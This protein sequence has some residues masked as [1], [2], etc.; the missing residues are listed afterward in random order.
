MARVRY[1]SKSRFKLA[2]ECPTKLFFTGKPEYG[3]NNLDNAFLEALAEGGFQVGELAK[4]YFPNGHEIDTLDADEAVKRTTELLSQ[5]KVTIYEPAFIFGKL[6]VRVD[7]LVKTGKSI[8]LVEVK[9]KSFDKSE[10]PSE[11]PGFGAMSSS[12]RSLIK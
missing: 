12:V 4:L 5:D 2:S 7:V 3:N 10:S 8:Q 11:V 9:A 1:L 6:L